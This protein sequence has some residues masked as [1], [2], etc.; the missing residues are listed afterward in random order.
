MRD[1]RTACGLSM[2]GDWFFKFD[3]KSEY[4]HVDIFPE[5]THFLGCS[6]TCNG[7]CRYFKFTVL[8]FG[9][10]TAPFLFTKIQKALVKHWRR[11]GLC[12]FTYLDDGAGAESNY[13][14]AKEMS[15]QVRQD[16]HDS[17]FVA[18]N[19][20]SQWDPVQCGELL[21]FIINLATGLFTVPERLV[22]VFMDMLKRIMNN[23][24]IVPARHLAQLSGSLS[25]MGLALGP[26][27]RLWTR[28]LYQAIQQSTS[29]DHRFLLSED[30]KNEI[31]FWHENYANSSQ[32]IWSAFPTIVMTYSDASDVVLI[33][34]G[35]CAELYIPRV[36]G[37]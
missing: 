4:H 9:L 36:V 3:Y 26:L 10:A 23:S 15:L 8:P 32:P 16:I 24:F 30:R 18:N 22:L 1:I 14:S 28:E 27:V 11:Q 37:C 25:S 17:G 19:E 2:K 7:Q 33:R 5:H 21:G 31:C 6:W 34:G 29:W 20:K 13:E 35:K 12:V